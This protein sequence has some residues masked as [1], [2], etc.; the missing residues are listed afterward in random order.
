MGGLAERHRRLQEYLEEE[1][2]CLYL[3]RRDLQLAPFSQDS[4]ERITVAVDWSEVYAYATGVLPVVG[5]MERAILDED[6]VAAAH[7]AALTVLFDRSPFPQLLLL[8]PY[9]EEMS[10]F[11][12]LLLS[13]VLAVNIDHPRKALTLESLSE[14]PALAAILPIAQRLKGENALNAESFAKEL[15]R[16]DR[17][18]IEDWIKE[19][20]GS[21]FLIARMNENKALDGINHLLRQGKQETGPRLANA[22]DVAPGLIDTTGFDY[23]GQEH[24]TEALKEALPGKSAAARSRDGE[25]LQYLATLNPAL[26][27]RGCQLLFVTRSRDMARVIAESAP[28]FICVSDVYQDRHTSRHVPT[29]LRSWQYF[30]ELGL[31]WNRSNEEATQARMKDR[32]EHV[33]AN[34][35][36]LRASK[37]P[38]RKLLDEITEGVSHEIVNL[39]TLVA[40]EQTWLPPKRRDAS[41]LAIKFFVSYVTDATQ[42]TQEREGIRR[43]VLESIGELIQNLSLRYPAKFADA[44]WH[45]R[46]GL[47][48]SAVRD[49]PDKILLSDEED[50]GARREL[51][52]LYRKLRTGQAPSQSEQESMLSRARERA[53]KLASPVSYDRVMRSVLYACGAFDRLSYFL[54]AAEDDD[55][56]AVLTP[57]WLMMRLMRADVALAEHARAT[58]NGVFRRAWGEAKASDSSV[59]KRILKLELL[60]AWLL[61]HL[62]WIEDHGEILGEFPL[63][64]GSEEAELT[65]IVREAEDAWHDAVEVPRWLRRALTN[66]C[67]YARARL[68]PIPGLSTAS[69]DTKSRTCMSDRMCQIYAKRLRGYSNKTADEEDTLG[70]YYLKRATDPRISAANRSRYISV[71]RERFDAALRTARISDR[72]KGLVSAHQALLDEVVS[73]GRTNQL[74]EDL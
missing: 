64:E 61:L 16:I 5:A 20:F 45:S 40:A 71:T 63:A 12:R 26:H 18:R 62:D 50:S 36:A 9:E 37:T 57:E 35:E 22:H 13:N 65:S 41:E 24:W 34:L 21:F 74:L 67:L 66:N 44:A 42:F 15:R 27:D 52:L 3:L 10:H 68:T 38:S 31:V 54:D 47:A 23:R 32:R 51:G 8:P 60:R 17:A 59:T 1:Q 43:R 11:V 39:R 69:R 46:L 4:A 30:F 28:E 14:S 72:T 73:R 48:R 29:I 25:A 2:R 7:Q 56:Q 49:L 33:A 58:A 53:P 6:L 19:H 70:Y 55:H